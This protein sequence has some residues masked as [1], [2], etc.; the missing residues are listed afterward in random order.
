[1]LKDITYVKVILVFSDVAYREEKQEWEYNQMQQTHS[2]P[3]LHLSH[4]QFLFNPS[5]ILN[6]KI[7]KWIF[8]G[9]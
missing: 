6:G 5:Y 8:E 9:S 3:F 7:S 1:M 4:P 2:E